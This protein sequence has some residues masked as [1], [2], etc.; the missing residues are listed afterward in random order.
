M[1]KDERISR[2][3]IKARITRIQMHRRIVI[4]YHIAF[5]RKMPY[6]PIHVLRSR[7][8]HFCGGTDLFMISFCFYVAIQRKYSHLYIQPTH[9]TIQNYYP[10][11]FCL[12]TNALT[13]CC[14]WWCFLFCFF[15]VCCYSRWKLPLFACTRRLNY[16]LFDWNVQFWVKLATSEVLPSKT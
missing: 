8:H 7:S 14:C 9:Q 1:G 4:L 15:F 12:F 10:W 13:I 2:T 16:I 6:I 5:T 11:I 3:N